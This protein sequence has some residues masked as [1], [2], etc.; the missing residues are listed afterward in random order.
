MAGRAQSNR[1]RWAANVPQNEP[2]TH[3]KPH[4]DGLHR[5]SGRLK[6]WEAAPLCVVPGQHGHGAAALQS[7]ACEGLRAAADG[8]TA[9]R[10]ATLGFLT[11]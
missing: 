8:F 7:A 11:G 2:S 5:P 9:P 6:N 10:G 3:P 4:A 1:A